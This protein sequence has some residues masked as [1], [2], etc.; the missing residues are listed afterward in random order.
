MVHRLA[1]AIALAAGP[2]LAA[3]GQPAPW[4]HDLP[5]GGLNCDVLVGEPDEVRYDIDFEL[6]LRP[7]LESLCGQCHVE[8]S[9]GAL[10]LTFNNARIDLLGDDETGAPTFQNPLRVRIK[11]FA[12]TDSFLFEKINCA[13]P[14]YGM[15]MPPNGTAPIALQKLVHDWIASGALMPHAPNAERL[16]IGNFE[17]IVRPGP[18]P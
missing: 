13:V 4:V 16:F 12:P 14:P 11:P 5:H 2:A 18:A 17:Q 15:R 1:L 3:P 8:Q 7:A 10:S 6:E 9:S